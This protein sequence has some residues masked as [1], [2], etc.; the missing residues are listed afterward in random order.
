MNNYSLISAIP[1]VAKVFEG[2]SVI[3]CMLTSISENNTISKSL[4]YVLSTLHLIDLLLSLCLFPPVASQSAS[5]I[6]KQCR[7]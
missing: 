6:L 5:F 4:S 1:I 3:S 7:F 2:L